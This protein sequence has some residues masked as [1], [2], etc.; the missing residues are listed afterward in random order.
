MSLKTKGKKGQMALKLDMSKAYDRVEWVF[1]EAVMRRLGFAEE[2]IRLI[3]MC[4]STV[5][6]SVLLN[7]VQCGQFNASRGIRQGD[8]L[9]PY[10]FLICAEGLSSLLQRADMERK[11]KGV[12]ASRGGPRLTH[13]FFADDSLLFCQASVQNC[14]A[15]C[16]ILQVYEE[17]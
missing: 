2:W 1:I 9:S 13:L 3:M 15:L 10:L 7:G 12:A 16:N 8:S 5:S 11:I 14:E 4:L 6:Y 17:A